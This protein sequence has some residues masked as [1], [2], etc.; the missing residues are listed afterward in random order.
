MRVSISHLNFFQ[1]GFA[2]EEKLFYKSEDFCRV[3]CDGFGFLFHFVT[4]KTSVSTN[5]PNCP[6]FKGKVHVT[7]VFVEC[8]ASPQT[9]GNL[10]PQSSERF[11]HLFMAMLP[12]T[13][14]NTRI[15]CYLT[16]LY[17][18]IHFCHFCS[19]RLHGE[20]CGKHCPLLVNFM[21]VCNVLIES[22][23]QTIKA[24]DVLFNLSL[25]VCY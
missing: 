24:V 11:I 2:I 6:Q 9:K 23:T 17:Q 21:K 5:S 15:V 20:H 4:W 10:T 1:L 16:N 19:Y 14:R 7:L 8:G 13:S 12:L 18:E 25:R 22:V 3:Y